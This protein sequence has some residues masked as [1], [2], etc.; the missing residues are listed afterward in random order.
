VSR[1]EVYSFGSKR[2]RRKGKSDKT[3]LITETG[4]RSKKGGIE[5]TNRQSNAKK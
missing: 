5:Q 4:C 1:G 3:Q 2:K